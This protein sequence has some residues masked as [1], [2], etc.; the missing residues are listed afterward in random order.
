MISRRHF[1]KAVLA[2]A[3]LYPSRRALASQR[4]ERTLSMYNIHT[5]EELTICYYANGRYDDAALAKIDYFLRCHYTNEVKPIDVAVLNLLCAIKD[6]FKKETP[7]H[8]ISGYRSPV[9]NEHLISLRKR[10][11]HNSL[12]LQGLAI[13]FAMPG[14][15]TYELFRTAKAFAAGGVGH[16]PDF[17]H[18]DVGPVR[19]W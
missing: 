11:S 15:S 14:M 3:V 4:S 10:V 16:Y 13:D 18:I 17:V 8:I 19:Y 6:V 1:L 5:H 2:G 7:A 9:Y 12:H